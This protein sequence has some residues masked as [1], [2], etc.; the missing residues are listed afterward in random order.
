[1]CENRKPTG[2]KLE[3]RIRLQTPLEEA[4]VVTRTEKWLIIDEFN[5][6]NPVFSALQTLSA[7]TA[8]AA[9]MSVI[10]ST[11]STPSQ[12]PISSAST[13]TSSQ[14]KVLQTPSTATTTATTRRSNIAKPER[15]VV[16]NNVAHTQNKIPPQQVD[17]DKNNGSS[18]EKSN[19]LEQ[20]EEELNR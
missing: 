9:G 14:Q 17:Q 13:S 5:R 10:P 15:E 20:A 4:E 18:L 19:E 11:P 8:N 2:G 3:V 7:Q 12:T 1:M 16:Q 6:N